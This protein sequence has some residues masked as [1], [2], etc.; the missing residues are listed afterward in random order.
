MSRLPIYRFAALVLCLTT[1]FAAI[2]GES[3]G[4]FEG[5]LNKYKKATTY[6]ESIATTGKTFC[7]SR[8]GSGKIP[9]STMFSSAELTWSAPK[10]FRV[11]FAISTQQGTERRVII[12]DGKIITR[13]KAGAAGWNCRSEEIRNDISI[14]NALSGAPNRGRLVFLISRD[15][16]KLATKESNP[17]GYWWYDSVSE[18]TGPGEKTFV[19]EGSEKDHGSLFWLKVDGASLSPKTL[20]MKGKFDESDRICTTESKTDFKRAVFNERISIN[21]LY[22]FPK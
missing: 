19:V 9:D 3:T 11:E 10:S 17:F 18:T 16:V 20:E 5:L 14:S 1:P 22:E 6:Q 7:E 13:C 2:R 4:I 12:S 21:N 15:Q 8:D